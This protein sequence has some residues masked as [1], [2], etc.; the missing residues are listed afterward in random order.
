MLSKTIETYLT[1]HYS[2]FPKKQYSKEPSWLEVWKDGR[3]S[4][5]ILL[6]ISPNRPYTQLCLH[7]C[8]ALLSSF[9]TPSSSHL[10]FDGIFP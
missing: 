6:S 4:A 7:Q 5:L 1:A 8:R 9:F 2:S 3:K 10:I